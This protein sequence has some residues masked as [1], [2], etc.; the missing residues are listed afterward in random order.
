V[1]RQDIGIVAAI[2]T[3]MAVCLGAAIGGCI[4]M[5]DESPDTIR[6]IETSPPTIWQTTNLPPSFTDA[7]ITTKPA[8]RAEVQIQVSEPPLRPFDPVAYVNGLAYCWQCPAPAME[9]YRVVAA[10]YGWNEIQIEARATFVQQIMAGESAFCWNS[11]AWSH[12]TYMLMPC[13]ERAHQGTR[14]DVGF[15]QITDVLRPFTCEKVG[16][17]TREATIAA[18]WPSMLAYVAVLTDQGKRPWCYYDNG[19]PNLH[20]RNGDCARWPG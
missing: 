17:C 10:F 9:A 18:P 5:T 12:D 2:L 7:A 3:L 19:R 1:K 15:G 11:R 6:T 4:D 20:I 13:T 8:V 14:E 16:I